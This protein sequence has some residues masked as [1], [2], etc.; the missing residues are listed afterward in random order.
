MTAMLS[1]CFSFRFT[2]MP[3]ALLTLLIPMQ[4]MAMLFLTSLPF[5]L[6][7]AVASCFTS[8]PFHGDA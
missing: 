5:C 2:S 3:H 4:C 7:R 1:L 6:R 8:F